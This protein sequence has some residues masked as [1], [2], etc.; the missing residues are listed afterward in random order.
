MLSTL[1]SWIISIAGIICIS[2]II[3]LILPEGNM[4]KYIKGI[5][6]FIIVLVIIM[7]LPKLLKTEVNFDKIFDYNKNISVDEDYLYQLNLNKI[8]IAKE[9]IEAKI[10]KQGYKNVSVY[11]SADIFDNKML[12]KSICVDLSGLVISPN[13]EHSDITKI[14]KDISSIITSYVD[15]SEEAI[16]YEQ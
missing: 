10:L 12:F 15:I 6:S 16:L 3:E 11:V 13:A 8:N 1:S 2:V 14:K 7:P 5:L 4:N 9:D